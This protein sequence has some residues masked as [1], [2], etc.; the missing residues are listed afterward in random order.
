MRGQFFVCGRT[1]FDEHRHIT[2]FSRCEPKPAM[3]EHS[4]CLNSVC[5]KG[6]GNPPCAHRMPAPVSQGVRW[7]RKIP[8]LQVPSAMADMQR[9][10]CDTC[11]PWPEQTAA[12]ADIGYRS[13]AVR[14]GQQT[15]QLRHTGPP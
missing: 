2:I 9:A 8:T 10:C 4:V 12:M 13:P 14:V 5:V 15:I 6:I 1:G 3:Q 7:L 11:G